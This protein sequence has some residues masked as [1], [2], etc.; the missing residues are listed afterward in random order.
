MKITYGKCKECKNC[1]KHFNNFYNYCDNCEYRLTLII[2]L[3]KYFYSLIIN[4]KLYPHKELDSILRNILKLNNMTKKCYFIIEN[5]N[6][7]Y[8]ET[9]I[10]INN[11]KLKNEK[12]KNTYLN[13][14]TK[15]F[16]FM[17]YK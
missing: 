11:L 16:L 15:T 4:L 8:N 3:Y 10:K 17:C 9:L 14:Q 2:K 12:I 7:L 5:F 13:S 6:I 1:N